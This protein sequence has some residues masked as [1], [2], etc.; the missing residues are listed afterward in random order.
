M[1]AVTTGTDALLA[2]VRE[3]LRGAFGGVKAAK[4]LAAL[5]SLAAE[6]ERLREK[7]DQPTLNIARRLLNAT[8]NAE[9]NAALGDL[10]NELEV[11]AR[12][13]LERV[14]AERDAA[15]ARLALHRDARG[16]DFAALVARLDKAEELLREVTRAE[17]GQVPSETPF[18]FEQRI[19]AIAAQ[20]FTKEKA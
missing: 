6:L 2:T 4:A 11:G 16:D 13:E 9:R 15:Q 17:W 14:K 19:H 8:D 12:A 5:D 7:P 18:Q 3:A 20:F 1:V 10:Y